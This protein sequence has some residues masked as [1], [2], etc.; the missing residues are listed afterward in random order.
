MQLDGA[1]VRMQGER[2]MKSVKID[3]A[4]R[5]HDAFG[6][7]GGSAC[8]KQLRQ[9]VFVELGEVG[10]QRYSTG[11]HRVVVLRRK[12]VGMG[13]GIEQVKGFHAAKILPEGVGESEKLVLKE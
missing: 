5:Q 11:K 4:M 10:A 6:I 8:V 7:G 3:I 2:S 12:P 13:R 1:C 9:S